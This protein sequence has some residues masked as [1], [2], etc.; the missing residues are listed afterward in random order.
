MQ[1]GCKQAGLSN[2]SISKHEERLLEEARGAAPGLARDRLIRLAR[3]ART[4]SDIQAWLCSPGLRAP[5]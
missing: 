4:A 1:R 2:Q 3:Q 5:Q